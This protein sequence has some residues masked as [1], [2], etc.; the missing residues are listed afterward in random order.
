MKA[1]FKPEK[2]I[3]MWHELHKRPQG[4]RRGAAAPG[5]ATRR[6]APS[7]DAHLPVRTNVQRERL[8]F[9][10]GCCGM[11]RKSHRLSAAI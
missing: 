10:G 4:R 6:T 9:Q 11:V 1:D 8:Q 3:S 5:S 7:L 2:S